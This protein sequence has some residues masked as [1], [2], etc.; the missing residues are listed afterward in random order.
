MP[1]SEP[2]W[3][4]RSALLLILHSPP[5]PFAKKDPTAPWAEV[6]PCSTAWSCTGVTSQPPTSPRSSSCAL[7]QELSVWHLPTHLLDT[8]PRTGSWAWHS[9]QCNSTRTELFYSPG[10]PVETSA[11]SSL[12]FVLVLIAVSCFPSAGVFPSPPRPICPLHRLLSPVYR[13]SESAVPALKLVALTHQPP[14]QKGR[15]SSI[16]T[17]ALIPIRAEKLK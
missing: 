3:E 12:S 15:N 17:F 8:Q 10:S 7:G 14:P 2:G 6:K 4:L 1:C 5:V 16:S 9:Q 13:A 11:L